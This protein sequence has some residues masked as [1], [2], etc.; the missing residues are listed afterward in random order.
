[1]L[2]QQTD[3]LIGKLQELLIGCGIALAAVV[4]GIAA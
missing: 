2:V 3:V 1:M 4:V